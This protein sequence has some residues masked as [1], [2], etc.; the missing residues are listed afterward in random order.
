MYRFPRFLHF[1]HTHDDSTLQLTICFH[2]SITAIILKTMYVWRDIS[3]KIKYMAVY[4]LYRK[5]A[6][7][8]N[9]QKLKPIVFFFFEN[10][11]SFSQTSCHHT[12]E[13]F[14][15]PITYLITHSES[16]K[17]SNFSREHFWS[18][19]PFFLSWFSSLSFL[20][21]QSERMFTLSRVKK[22]QQEIRAF[23]KMPCLA[24]SHSL[25]LQGLRHNLL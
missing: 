16:I 14:K 18:N 13:V 25:C 20:I 9:L 15:M 7:I 23:Q 24:L 5:A 11:A 6:C 21:L 1:A 2:C 3:L 12:N 4:K 10:K 22:Q 8:F 19:S 17:N